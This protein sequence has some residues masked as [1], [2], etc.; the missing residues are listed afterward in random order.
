MIKLLTPLLVLALAACENAM[1]PEEIRIGVNECHK[2]EL[3]AIPRNISP[4]GLAI[5]GI[6]CWVP[7]DK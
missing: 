6:D 7:N 3:T 1:T 4:G 5:T 2:Y